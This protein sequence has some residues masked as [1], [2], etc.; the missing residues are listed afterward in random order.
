MTWSTSQYDLYIMKQRSQANEITHLSLIRLHALVTVLNLPLL[1]KDPGR[2]KLLPIQ[3]FSMTLT[4]GCKP[5]WTSSHRA[6]CCWLTPHRR[7][8]PQ[9]KMGCVWGENFHC[10]VVLCTQDGFCLRISIRTTFEDSHSHLMQDSRTELFLRSVMDGSE[11]KDRRRVI[12]GV[13]A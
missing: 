11:S 2:D 1:Q 4:W 10:F 3:W 12:F 13:R 6:P 5:A 7:V 8:E 9:H